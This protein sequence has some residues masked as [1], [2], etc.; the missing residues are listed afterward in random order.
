MGKYQRIIQLEKTTLYKY[1]YITLKYD[2]I[3]C[4]IYIVTMHKSYIG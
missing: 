3:Y 4:N 1:I 2:K